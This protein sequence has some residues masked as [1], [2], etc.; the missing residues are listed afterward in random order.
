MKKGLEKLEEYSRFDQELIE[1]I[2]GAN[3]KN[4]KLLRKA[5]PKFVKK[6]GH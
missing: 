1:L 2:L 5:Y 6:F 3:E 4:L